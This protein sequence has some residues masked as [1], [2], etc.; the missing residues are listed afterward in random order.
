MILERL[1]ATVGTTFGPGAWIRLDQARIDAFAD[2]TG[3]RQWIHVEPARAAASAFGG[4]VA[5]GYLTLSLIAAAHFDLGVFPPDEGVRVINYGL[6]EVRF[7]APVASGSR[8]RTSITVDEAADRRRGR[9]LLRTSSRVWV[10]GM[11][12]HAVAAEALFLV[13]PD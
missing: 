9:V 2:V 10:E 4:T 12:K 5:H 11:P 7:L 3:D 1:R 8:V 6:D 13:L